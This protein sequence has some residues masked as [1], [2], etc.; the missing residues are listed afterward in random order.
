[1]VIKTKLK[2]R[3]RWSHSRW[4][5]ECAWGFDIEPRI[6]TYSLP[7]FSPYRNGRVGSQQPAKWWFWPAR[8]PMCLCKPF[9]PNFHYSRAHTN[10][11]R[12]R[13]EPAY[14]T[15]RDRAGHTPLLIV[16]LANSHLLANVGCGLAGSL[17]IVAPGFP[18]L[19]TPFTDLQWRSRSSFPCDLTDSSRR[20]PFGHAHIRRKLYSERA[21]VFTKLSKCACACAWMCALK[22]THTHLETGPS[23]CTVVGGDGGERFGSGHINLCK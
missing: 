19:C 1:M 12:T 13:T 6:V 8:T 23:N 10:A 5:T 21:S 4:H 22:H 17:A 7:L 16:H 20:N 18:V 3:N 9:S 15:H 14:T 2:P 11:R